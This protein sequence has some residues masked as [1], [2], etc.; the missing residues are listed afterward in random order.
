MSGNIQNDF[1]NQHKIYSDNFSLG[2][3]GKDF[4]N[5]AALISLIG[6]LVLKIRVKRPRTTYL[7]V[8]NSLSKELKLDSKFL[9]T[10]AIVCENLAYGCD[11]FPTFG[12]E[13]KKIPAKIKELLENYVPF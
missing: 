12:I 2:F 8:I 3:F 9:Y 1:E 5:K 10:L 11:S 6:Y 7:E 13:D 4:S